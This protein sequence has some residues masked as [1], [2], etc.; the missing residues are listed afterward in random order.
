MARSQPDSSTASDATMARSAT[1]PSATAP[2]PTAPSAT[3][4][5]ATAPSPTARSAPRARG[6]SCP[7]VIGEDGLARWSERHAEAWIGMLETH[8]RLTRA[9]DAELESEHGLSLSALE[10]LARL[11]GAQ[12][13][14]LGLSALAHACGLS[15]SR[16]SRIVDGLEG[17]GLVVR[18]GVPDD[19]RAVVGEL[20]KRGLKLV[21]AAQCSHFAAVQ[22][23]FFEHLTDEE[24]STLAAI[25][26]RF[27]PAAAS[28]CAAVNEEGSRS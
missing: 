4:P 13:R 26:S 8:K 6:G 7:Y 15:L 21:R 17:R 2:G 11:G 22:R 1:V 5:G 23:R 12:R 20:T 27:V 25:F 28:D 10:V 18:R 14:S 3:A 19:A 24:V 9:L 16:V